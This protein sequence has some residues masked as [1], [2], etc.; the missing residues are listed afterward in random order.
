MKIA[1]R[2]IEKERDCLIFYCT[3]V[4]R[5]GRQEGRPVSA[6][7]DHVREKKETWIARIKISRVKA[8][9]GGNVVWRCA[10]F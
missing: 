7:V 3:I 10:A 4:Q 1:F 6:G 9:I 8:R 5:E 2:I